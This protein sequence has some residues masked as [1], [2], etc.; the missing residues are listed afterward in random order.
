MDDGTKPFATLTPTLLARKGG[1]R[2]AMR[3]QTKSLHD[4]N[5]AT[6]REMFDDLGWNDMGED[7]QEGNEETVEPKYSAQVVP[8]AIDSSNEPLVSNSSKPARQQA[9]KAAN[10]SDQASEDEDDDGVGEDKKSSGKRQSS[11]TLKLDSQR[12]L[13][14]RLA[15]TVLERSAQEILIEAFDNYFADMTEIELLVK[16]IRKRL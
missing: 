11:V 5:E 6:A 10:R 1:A 3:R 9:V 2:P 8:I 15:A 4:F 16:N 7:A 14:L 12:H 13:K